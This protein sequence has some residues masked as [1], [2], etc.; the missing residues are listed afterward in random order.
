M[1]WIMKNKGKAAYLYSSL[2]LNLRMPAV[3]KFAFDIHF[4]S[5]NY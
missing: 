5:R 3:D 4:S 2:I 1:Y